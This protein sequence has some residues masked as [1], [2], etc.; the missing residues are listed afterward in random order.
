VA[1]LGASQGSQWLAGGYHA[2]SGNDITAA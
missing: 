1:K 2:M